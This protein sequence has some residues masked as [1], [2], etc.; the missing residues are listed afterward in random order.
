MKK[1][2]LTALFV[3][4][5]LFGGCERSKAEGP[6]PV[7]KTKA[8]VT[9]IDLGSVNCIP[10]KAMLP[11]ME[12]LEK[13]YGDQIKIVFHDVWKDQAPA[14]QY[15]IRLIPTQVFLDE[16]GVEFHRHEGFYAKEEIDKLLEARGLKR[17]VKS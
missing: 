12:A 2:I 13:E 4:I 3:T 9:F 14:R 6:K 10:C 5:G 11:V 8:Q 15:R 1:Y 7:G 16:N 17:Q